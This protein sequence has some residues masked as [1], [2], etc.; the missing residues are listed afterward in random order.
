MQGRIAIIMDAAGQLLII[1]AL[2]VGN[3]R[4]EKLD[5]GY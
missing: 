1:K 4:R 2:D 5:S 3:R